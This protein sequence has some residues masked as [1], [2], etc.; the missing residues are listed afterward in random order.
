MLFV[1]ITS[2]RIAVER[3]H[4]IAH[5]AD[6]ALSRGRNL[7]CILWLSVIHLLSQRFAHQLGIY[8]CA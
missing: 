5:E 2:G 7:F 8:L 4:A 6:T 3:N 1:L